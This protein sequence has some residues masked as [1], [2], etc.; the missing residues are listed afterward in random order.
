M[1]SYLSERTFNAYNSWLDNSYDDVCG[2]IVFNTAVVNLDA[3]SDF[4]KN[5]SQKHNEMY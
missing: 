1:A 2:K 4:C 3:K 5:L